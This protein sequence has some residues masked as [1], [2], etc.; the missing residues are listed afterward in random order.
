MHLFYQPDFATTTFL[1]EEEAQHAL[2]V[3]RMKVGEEIGLLDGKGNFSKAIL[4]KTDKKNCEYKIQHSEYTAPLSPALHLAL[5]PTKNADRV[6]WL[7]EKATE[8]GVASF[9]FFLSEHSERK[10]LNTERLEK[11]VISAL[12]QSKGA[13]LPEIKPLQKYSDFLKN[14][15]D[16][17]RKV[18]CHQEEGKSVPF[19][20]LIQS[21]ADTIVLIGPEGDFSLEELSMA[22]SAGFQPVT[23]GA[24]RLRT[25]TAALAACAAFHLKR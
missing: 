13:W 1:N 19:D 16:Q 22:R 3:L 15:P 20:T 7:V 25:E 5:A 10:N 11:I 17:N 12:K 14:I 8:M 2:R 4:V 23:L 9:S 18:I 21:P 24:L 6:E